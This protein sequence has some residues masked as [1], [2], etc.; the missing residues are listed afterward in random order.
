MTFLKQQIYFA[1]DIGSLSRKLFFGIYRKYLAYRQFSTATA[2]PYWNDLYIYSGTSQGIYYG[3]QG[4]APNRNLIFE[5]YMSHFRQQSQYYH[6]QV[7]FL[8]SS[9]GVIQYKYFQA[10]DGGISCAIGVQYNPM[11]DYFFYLIK[12]FFF[13]FQ[14][15]SFHAIF[16]RYG[17]LCAAEYTSNF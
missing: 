8:E 17:K 4:I 1:F 10:T 6:F 12:C 5:F 2:F 13:S 3:A 11:K 14:Q 16:I 7:I 9:P 15:Q